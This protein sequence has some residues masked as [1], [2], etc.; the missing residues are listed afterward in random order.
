MQR[1]RGIAVTFICDP[2]KAELVV[3][4]GYGVFFGV[5]APLFHHETVFTLPLL[6][7]IEADLQKTLGSFTC[8]AMPNSILR[9][10]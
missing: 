4:V 3:H 1:D 6:R 10:L 8:K 7:P 2:V 5:P 9:C